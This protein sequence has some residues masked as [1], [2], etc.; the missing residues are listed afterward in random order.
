MSQL[1]PKTIRTR[2]AAAALALA[3]PLAPPAAA[4][5]NLLA[6]GEF[7]N[8]TVLPWRGSNGILLL[9]NLDR[10]NNADSGSARLVH[11]EETYIASSMFSEYLSVEGGAQVRLSGYFRTVASPPAGAAVQ[12]QVR[13]YTGYGSASSCTGYIAPPNPNPYK[14]GFLTLTGSWAQK[15]IVHNAPSNA[16]C[17]EVQL[18]T[19]DVSTPWDAFDLLADGLSFTAEQGLPSS[20]F[21]SGFES[22]TTTG[23]VVVP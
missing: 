13:Y 20:I 14:S 4:A 12:L 6:N 19:T 9:S 16:R 7:S 21:A 22:G 1:D 8:F 23:W 3:V 11:P 5:A 18:D 2:C 10:A 17:A 15:S